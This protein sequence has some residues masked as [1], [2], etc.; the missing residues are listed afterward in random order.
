MTASASDNGRRFTCEADNGLGVVV[1]ANATLDVLHG[2]RWVSAPAGRMDV[3]EGEDLSVSAHASANPGPI[4]YSWWVG[5]E[6][7]AG[8]AGDAGG[9]LLLPSVTRL[10]A[11]EYSVRAESPDAAVTAS[12]TVNVLFGPEDVVATERVVVERGG[13]ATLLCSAHGNPTPTITWTRDV[14]GDGSLGERLSTGAGKARMAVEGAARADSG[15]YLCT[16]SSVVGVAPAHAA[17]VVVK[18]APWWTR[19]ETDGQ[20]SSGGSWAATGGE[21]HLECRVW[22]FPKPSFTWKHKNNTTLSSGD[23]YDIRETQLEDGVVEWSSAL[24]VKGVARGDYGNYSCVAT[25]ALGSHTASLVLVP[26]P[27]PATPTNLTVMSLTSDA[28][29]L[30][31]SA[32]P[33]GGPATGFT[34]KYWPAG[35]RVF[36]LEDVDGGGTNSTTVSGLSA[37]LEYFFSVQAYNAQGRSQH[38]APPT[39]VTLLGAVESASSP[40]T[41]EGGGPRVIRVPR[42]LLLIM[43]LA[44]TALL[45]LNMA[46][47]ACFVRRRAVH[48]NR[49]VSASSSKNTTLEVFSTATSPTSPQGDG[50]PLTTTGSTEDS[51]KGA[52]KGECQTDVDSCD[53]TK[54]LTYHPTGPAA[55]RV[56]GPLLADASRLERPARTSGQV[57]PVNGSV[58]GCS[59]VAQS[60]LV[61]SERSVAPGA[62]NH[63]DVCPTS[64]ATTAQYT[65]QHSNHLQQHPQQHQYIQL[66]QLPRHQYHQQLP[67]PQAPPNLIQNHKQQQLQHPNFA[68]HPSHTYQLADPAGAS[69]QPEARAPAPAT[70]TY[71]TLNPRDLARSGDLMAGSGSVCSYATV[72]PRRQ[73]PPTSRPSTLQRNATIC[74]SEMEPGVAVAVG[75]AEGSAAGSQKEH[76]TSAEADRAPAASTTSRGLVRRASLFADFSWQSPLQPHCPLDPASSTRDPDGSADASNS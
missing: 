72:A 34:L 14:D 50:L 36:Q 2:P 13:S 44:G 30:A 4:R 27:T 69:S 48:G 38:S 39:P 37:G 41:G 12:F 56:M 16:A 18:Q 54:L 23:K 19:E 5:G 22:A 28:V 43:T 58:Y 60:D 63:P 64:T 17:L 8:G 46:I 42:L 65:H 33:A 1:A 70:S 55:P 49:G 52:L 62:A 74:T 66:Q 59:P 11:G 73:R 24:S 9:E 68:H 3:K 20:P 31:W 29:T 76:Q 71:A 51:Q 10:Q 57:L 61:L 47:I 40:S 7:L 75:V 32:S 25:N 15:R 6:R 45:A 67:Q 35:T 21:G 26:P 53:Q